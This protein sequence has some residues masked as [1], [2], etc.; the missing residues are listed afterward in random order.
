LQFG[1]QTL[2][3]GAYGVG[4][5]EGGEFVVLDLAASDIFRVASQKDTEIKRPYPS[6]S[7]PRRAASIVCTRDASSWNSAGQIIESCPK[8]CGSIPSYVHKVRVNLMTKTILLRRSLALSVLLLSATFAAGQKAPKLL[9][10]GKS[11]WDHVKVLAD[12]SMEGAKPEA[13]VCGKREPTS[14]NNSAR[15]A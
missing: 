15:R 11:W 9:F 2:K 6:R 1:A 3:P 13:W 8:P 10:D 4:F 7:P 5:I 14:W 12:D